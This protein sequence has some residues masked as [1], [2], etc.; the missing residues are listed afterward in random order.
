VATDWRSAYAQG[1]Y[2]AAF[3]LLKQ[4]PSGVQGV[5]ERAR[6]PDDLIQISD[7]ARGVKDPAAAAQA[8]ARILK[9]FSKHPLAASAACSQMRYLV[10]N[11]KNDEAARLAQEYVTNHP[12]DRQCKGEAQQI[13]RGGDA[14][15]GEEEAPSTTSSGTEKVEPPKP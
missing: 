11:G 13:L 3:E 4:Q 10:A 8:R 1:D 2:A 5:I 12:D 15:D 14:V 7:V 9:D 6:T